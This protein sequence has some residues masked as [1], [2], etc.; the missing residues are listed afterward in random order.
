MKDLFNDNQNRF[1]DFS[2]RENGFL[3]DYS[4]NRVTEKTIKLLID[5]AKEAHLEDGISKMFSGDR[6]NQTENRAVLHTALRDSTSKKLVVEGKDI[7]PQIKEELE[8]VKLFSESVIAGKFKG[9]TGKKIEK[10]VNIGIGGSDLGPAMVCEA[11][12]DFQ[13]GPQVAF[14]SN[15]DGAHLHET[16]K[17]CDVEST[18]FII[19]SKTFTTQETMTNALAAKEWLLDKLGAENAVS[20]HFVAVSTNKQ[21]VIDFGIKEENQFLFWDWVG[22]RYSLWSSV[23]LSIAMHVGFENFEKLLEGAHQADTNFREQ[24]FEENVPVLM[25][26]LG[27]WYT[28]FFNSASHAVLPYS[29]YLSRFSAYLQQGDMESN[30]KR[31][32]RNGNLCNYNTG[33]IIWGE[34]GTNGQHAF[35]Q[36]IH[37]GTHLI[38]SDFIAFKKERHKFK[39]HNKK[40][41]SNFLAQTRALM[42]GRNVEEVKSE[43]DLSTQPGNLLP[44]KVFPGNIPT[45]SFLF[46]ELNPSTL[47]YLTA[48]YEHKIFVQGY[49][50]NVFSFD[51]WGVELGKVLAKEILNEINHSSKTNRFDSST[52]GILSY[53]N[54]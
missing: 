12:K 43:S 25:A 30:G 40:L 24:P 1:K 16:L 3:F 54:G 6:I 20:K 21:G 41:L 11:L 53:L 2:I 50:W 48:M 4:K 9:F 17:H 13:V 33:P 7:L 51:Q 32:D 28:N 47:G 31:V 39:D 23:G 29:Q 35:Y 5:F 52:N 45:N 22:G 14:V 34:P 46:D 27:I 19:V 36:L 15:V 37:Q 38:P 44:Y 26:L 42:K 10:I 18:L 8:K 49:L